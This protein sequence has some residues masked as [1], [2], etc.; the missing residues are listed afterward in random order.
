MGYDK[1][2]Q[3]ARPAKKHIKLTRTLT[4]AAVWIPMRGRIM[5]VYRDERDVWTNK[6]VGNVTMNGL[7]E[8]M[9]YGVIL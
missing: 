3:T 6:M 5:G 9:G 2:P 4:Y 1:A 8:K 7:W